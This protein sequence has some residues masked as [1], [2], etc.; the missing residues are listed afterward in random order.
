MPQKVL[1]PAF[2]L[3]PSRNFLIFLNILK[4]VKDNWDEAKD[5]DFGGQFI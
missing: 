4:T 3:Q 2:Y 5:F 1:F